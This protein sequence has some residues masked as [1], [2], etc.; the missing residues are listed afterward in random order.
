M[1]ISVSPKADS[2]GTAIL[3]YDAE[4]SNVM[5]GSCQ[6]RFRPTEW[7]RNVSR[8]SMPL[9]GNNIELKVRSGGG[10]VSMRCVVD[11]MIQGRK[12]K[13]VIVQTVNASASN[14]GIVRPT[15]R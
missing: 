6:L 2:P 12:R 11:A 4:L 8:S 13:H 9:K 7:G 15:A 14:F 1:T 5:G 3:S 10:S